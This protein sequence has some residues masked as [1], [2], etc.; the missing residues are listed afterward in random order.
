MGKPTIKDVEKSKADK[1]RDKKMGYKEGLK[2]DKTLDKKE[3]ASMKKS[4]NK[5]K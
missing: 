2:K 5:K 1:I 3:L 4:Y